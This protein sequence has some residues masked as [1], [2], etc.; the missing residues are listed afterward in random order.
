MKKVIIFVLFFFIILSFAIPQENT[1]IPIPRINLNVEEANSPQDVALSLQM[2][3]LVSILTLAPSLM[4]LMTSFLRI[5]IVFDFL[6]KALS[7]QQ[8][9]PNQ[10]LF[11]LAL[12]L[13]FFVM[14]PTFDQINQEALQ[15]FLNQEE[16]APEEQIGV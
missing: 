7:L 15:P 2:L 11:G 1:N 4:I 10:V 16:I 14:W 13:T 12:F 9:P 8:M 6:K 3:F 5:A